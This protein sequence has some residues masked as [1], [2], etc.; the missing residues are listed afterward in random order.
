M[1]DLFSP[2]GIATWRDRLARSD[3]FKQAAG[4]WSGSVLLVERDSDRGGRNTFLELSNGEIVVAREATA[5]DIGAAEFVLA[6]S[7]GSWN[8]LVSGELELLTAAMTGQLKL[9][10][11]NVMRLA[12]HARAA[13]ALLGAAGEL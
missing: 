10:R 3:R 8:R 2:A 12:G 11:G 5:G 13:A 9:E 4:D 7:A 6:A 1:T